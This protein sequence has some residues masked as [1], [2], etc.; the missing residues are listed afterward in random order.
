MVQ[1]SELSKL[2]N[3]L[4]AEEADLVFRFMKAIVKK[5]Q[6]IKDVPPELHL[7]TLTELE[8]IF[9]VTHRTLLQWV[10]DGKLPVKKIG[11]K[12]VITEKELI[13][14]APGMATESIKGKRN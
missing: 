11:G 2:I 12:W 10:K 9:Q 14:T 7:Y 1:K 3:Q 4:T 5:N 6:Q 13:E 8:P